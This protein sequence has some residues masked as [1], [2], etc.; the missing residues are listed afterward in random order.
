MIRRSEK[1]W[2]IGTEVPGQQVLG[3]EFRK[4]VRGWLLL[5]PRLTRLVVPAIKPLIAAG[6][7]M[8]PLVNLFES[9]YV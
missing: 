9:A 8:L 6:Q 5:S 3:P 1:R 4:A 2:L 7:S